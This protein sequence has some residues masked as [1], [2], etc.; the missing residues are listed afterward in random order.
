M[1]RFSLWFVIMIAL[2]MAFTVPP[3][4]VQA[5][6]MGAVQVTEGNICTDV[7]N[8]VCYNSSTRFMA[9]VDE[10]FCFTKIVGAQDDTYVTH[11]WYFGETE[12]A[13]VRLPVRG[14]SW[15]TWSSKIIQP[16]EIGDWHV[17]VLGGDGQLLMVIPFEIHY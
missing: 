8:R 9:P 13:R 3:G 7:Q 10:L 16:H 17:D 11:V 6:E 15:R 1:K 14:S 5:Q 4:N 2:L 12:R